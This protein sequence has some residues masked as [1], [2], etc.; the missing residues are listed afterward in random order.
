MEEG[1]GDMVFGTDIK[2]KKKWSKT[3]CCISEL[4]QSTTQQE[5]LF[6]AHAWAGCDTTSAIYQKGY[7]VQDGVF[8]S[9]YYLLNQLWVI[10]TSDIYCQL[11]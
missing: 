8:C 10:I 2:A 5:T 4:I 1:M 6:F 11:L 9:Q 3:I 7:H